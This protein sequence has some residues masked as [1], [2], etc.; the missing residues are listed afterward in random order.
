M[1]K[2]TPFIKNCKQKLL[3]GG[4]E[5]V[6]KMRS[7]KEKL[8]KKGSQ[9]WTSFK[10]Q[11]CICPICIT[12][13]TSCVQTGYMLL[14]KASLSLEK[15]FGPRS[16]ISIAVSTRRQGKGEFSDD[17]WKRLHILRQHTFEFHRLAHTGLHTHLLRI[18]EVH[19]HP[20]W[21]CSGTLPASFPM[22]W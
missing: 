10:T 9:F 20:A 11:L 1:I 15:L 13:G 5:Q 17:H 12:S 7:I 3:L 21:Q 14:S 16:S 19:L 2:V 22:H 4:L 18:C 8:P 6:G